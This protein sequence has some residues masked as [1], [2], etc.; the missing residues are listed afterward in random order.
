MLD[1]NNLPKQKHEGI[2]K[3]ID[4][5][6]VV[7]LAVFFILSLCP[8]YSVS[9][10]DVITVRGYGDTKADE[11]DSWS[12]LSYCGLP[13]NHASVSDWQA[14]QY[15]ENKKIIKENEE[16]GYDGFWSELGGKLGITQTN[17]KGEK[18]ADAA[19]AVNQSMK[20]M[21]IIMPLFSLWI[22][23]S[24]PASMCVYWI[25][26]AVFSTLFDGL[27]T[28]HY[29]KVYDAEDEIKREK[30]AEEAAIEAEKEARRAERRAANPDGVA[31]P[32]TSRRKVKKQLKAAESS[33]FDGLGKL[34]EEQKEEIRQ[35]AQEKEKPKGGLS[36]DPNR[37]YSRG[38]AYDPNRY[39]KKAQEPAPQEDSQQSTDSTDS[40]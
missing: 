5:V 24:M 32:N 2:C 30:A 16:N 29:K 7:L 27:L 17:D 36:G 28:L 11:D 12:L 18:D 21:M 15:K 13:Y 14:D 25:A 35:K 33:E 26:Q 37:P 1:M 34:T 23:F 22:G 40:Q 6:L 9:K 19:A 38:R 20:T 8:Y 31:N 39:G 10:G 3:I 4:Y